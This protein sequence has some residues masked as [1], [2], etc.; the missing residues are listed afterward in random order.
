MIRRDFELEKGIVCKGFIHNFSLYYND[1]ALTPECDAI[2]YIQNKLIA[3]RSHGV[4]TVYLPEIHEIESEYVMPR[5]ACFKCYRNNAYLKVNLGD[6][7]YIIDSNVQIKLCGCR[8][9]IY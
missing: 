4:V 8:T 6:S 9:P 5:I 3:V 1:V 2:A 7:T